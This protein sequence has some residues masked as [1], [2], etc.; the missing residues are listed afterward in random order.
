MKKY[1]VPEIEIA[2]FKAC[3]IVTT[4]GGDVTEPTTLNTYDEDNPASLK[5][6]VGYVQ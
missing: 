5:G 2:S 4:S 1:F 3:D 6:K